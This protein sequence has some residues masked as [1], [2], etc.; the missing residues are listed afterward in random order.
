[1]LKKGDIVQFKCHYKTIA[2]GTYARV[3]RGGKKTTIHYNLDAK[4]GRI[5]EL[6]VPPAFV[7]AYLK[8]SSFQSRVAVLNEIDFSKVKHHAAMSH[9]TMALSGHI[10]YKGVKIGLHNEGFG[11]ETSFD[12]RQSELLDEINQRIR[13]ETLAI[14]P[15]ATD[16]L[17]NLEFAVSWSI[18][19]IGLADFPEYAVV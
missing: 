12:H 4:T 9:E 5:M 11:G 8:K 14:N 10:T 3:V 17:L 1:M 18:E 19:A 6:Q 15:D 13:N 16:F 2:E 7:D